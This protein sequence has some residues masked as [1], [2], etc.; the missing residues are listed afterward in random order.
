MAGD[1]PTIRD[2]HAYRQS[3]VEAGES[4][5]ARAGNLDRS[6]FFRYPQDTET[7]QKEISKIVD[8]GGKA[9]IL[10]IGIG[11]LEEPLSYLGA[12]YPTLKDKGRSLQ[13]SVDFAMIELRSRSDVSLANK[14]L[15][16]TYKDPV[17]GVKVGAAFLK[18][19]EMSAY[20][21]IPLE[22]QK[23]LK[24]AFQFSPASGEYEFHPDIISFL[25]TNLNDPLHGH[26]DTA[27]E[28]YL[29]SQQQD[30]FDIVTCNNVLQH[31]GG[32]EAYPTPLKNRY[33]SKEQ[34]QTFYDVVNSVLD[35]VKPGGL[36]IMHTDGNDP[37]DA[38]GLLTDKIL[39]YIG[40]YKKEFRKE[41]DGLYR[42]LTPEEI[43]ERFEK[44]ATIKGR[45]ISLRTKEAHISQKDRTKIEH[46][47]VGF[48][49]KKNINSRLIESGQLPGF[50]KLTKQQ[51]QTLAKSIDVSRLDR[52]PTM[53]IGTQELD[54]FYKK[55]KPLTFFQRVQE[56]W[57]SIAGRSE[58]RVQDIQRLA[59][60]YNVDLLYYPGSGF[61]TIAR[62][63]LGR[64]HVIHLSAED[65]NGK[66]PWYF[67]IKEEHD[68]ENG[69]Q[70][71]DMNVVGDFRDS[72]F[73]DKIFDAILV[74]GIPTHYAIDS[75]D[76]LERVLKN[77]GYVFFAPGR[78]PGL[79]LLREKIAEKMTLVKKFRD[80]EVYLN[81]SNTRGA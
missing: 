17:S 80:I 56:G 34:M 36:L 71:H 45:K 51:Q 58:I 41:G 69:I 59:Q 44:K 55:I 29:G 5:K 66:T 76:D 30:R 27:L 62:D 20:Q 18:P 16:K 63:A 25:E 14:G 13:N 23:D 60:E 47:R 15:G 26:F 64:E 8:A 19:H 52:F 49:E 7:L 42:R 72:P 70:G 22:P 50:E 28:N 48:K 68:R 11:N 3:L 39:K 31:L 73:Q 40:L 10:E 24:S 53:D 61:D 2:V 74:K 33:M 32:K 37:G 67:K 35:R 77:D 81:S 38:K 4:S 43:R 79:D 57:R 65:D 21:A 1:A 6:K 12:I 75:V 54:G 46:L 78:M 9:K